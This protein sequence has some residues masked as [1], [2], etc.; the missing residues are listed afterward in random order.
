MIDHN[1]INDYFVGGGIE[2]YEK[3]FI[4]RPITVGRLLT[5]R[6]TSDVKPLLG[7]SKG[8]LREHYCVCV[9]VRSLILNNPRSL[10]KNA[11]TYQNMIK[12][13]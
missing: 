4:L 11:K 8:Q 7:V 12:E 3:C 2:I 6:L 9:S 13:G 10:K 5:A 1:T